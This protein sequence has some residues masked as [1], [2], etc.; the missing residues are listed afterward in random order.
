MGGN[1]LVLFSQSGVLMIIYDPFYLFATVWI[2]LRCQGTLIY[3]HL[4][5]EQPEQQQGLSRPL[6]SWQTPSGS[7]GCNLAERQASP[8]HMVAAETLKWHNEQRGRGTVKNIRLFNQV[9]GL[10]FFN[11]VFIIIIME[12]TVINTCIS[13][14]ALGKG[15]SLRM[16]GG[17]G[18]ALGRGN[19]YGSGWGEGDATHW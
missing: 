9:K 13:P 18:G 16:K 5:Q 10:F 1:V 12:K 6:L 14:W 3:Q 15:V 11:C 8:S 7:A 17:A 2:V 4:L 19:G